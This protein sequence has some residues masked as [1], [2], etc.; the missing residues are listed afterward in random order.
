M[1]GLQMFLQQGILP[2]LESTLKIN[3]T[4]KNCFTLDDVNFKAINLGLGNTDSTLDEFIFQKPAWMVDRYGKL[5]EELRPKRIFELGIW[6]GG[7]CVFFHKIANANKLVTIDLSEER[8]SAVDEYIKVNKLKNSLVP[9]YGV[10]Q[11]DIPLLQK[12]ATEEFEG[13]EIDLV[14][15]DA[16]H[17]LDETRSSF[18]ALFPLVRPGGVYVIEDWPWAHGP[19]DLPDNTMGFYPEREPLTELI[20]ELILACPS[21]NAYI[22]KIEVDR[23]S[24]TVWRGDGAIEAESFNISQCCL[25]RGRDLIKRNTAHE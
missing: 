25:A 10:D 8:I 20:F 9:M 18:N 12:I 1:T 16:S 15:D 24:V 6:Q 13:G 11:S 2:R 22:D 4:A 14:I 17:F 21:T 5:I 3:W 19:I 7:S 23:N